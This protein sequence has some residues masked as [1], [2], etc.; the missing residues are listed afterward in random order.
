MSADS[1]VED[2]DGVLKSEALVVPEVV[3]FSTVVLE[4]SGLPLS[5]LY[6]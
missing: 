3:P 1:G 5:E 6:R 4:G 2:V